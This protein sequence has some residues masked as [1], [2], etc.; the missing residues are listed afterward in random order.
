MQKAKNFLDK[1]QLKEIKKL[2]LLWFF[3]LV[4]RPGYQHLAQ[5]PDS[6]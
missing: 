3:N 1:L 2:E 5:N 6:P 4:R